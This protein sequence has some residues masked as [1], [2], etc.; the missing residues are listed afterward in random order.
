MAI[1]ALIIGFMK[2]TRRE[3]CV[4]N[5]WDNYCYNCFDNKLLWC[6]GFFACNTIFPA[7]Y[8][9]TYEDENTGFVCLLDIYYIPFMVFALGYSSG[10]DYYIPH[11]RYLFIMCIISLIF[12]I[13]IQ[14]YFIYKT[15]K[16][17]KSCYY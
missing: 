16:S 9:C 11:V 7:V 5:P 17:C 8:L 6:L 12:N 13:Y 3:N 2:E 4:Y 1:F 14:L 15:C 10:C